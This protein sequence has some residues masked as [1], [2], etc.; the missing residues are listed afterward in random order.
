MKWGLNESSLP[1]EA[2]LPPPSEHISPALPK[3]IIMTSPEVVALQ[4]T[5][6]EDTYVPC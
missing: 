6:K 4:D 5:E 3:E 2:S 1:V